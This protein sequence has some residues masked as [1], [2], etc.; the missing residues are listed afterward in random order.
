M[1]RDTYYM[2]L[3]ID[4]AVKAKQKGEVPIGCVIVH[5]DQVIA[6]GHNLR[7]TQQNATCHAEIIAIQ[8]ACQYLNSWRLENAELFVT[9]EPCPMCAGGIIMSRVK[10]VV[11]GAMDPKGGCVGSL[12]NLLDDHRFNHQCEIKSGVLEEECSQ[13]LKSFFKKIRERKKKHIQ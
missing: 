11:F 9:L 10:R 1:D 13:L 4:E 3:A 5:N 8:E 2:Q 12:M 6:T 7:E